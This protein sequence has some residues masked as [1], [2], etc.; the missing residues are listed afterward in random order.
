M[1]SKVKGGEF[2]RLICK[3]LSLWIS[4]GKRD[5]L[6][7][8]SAMSGG[9]ATV[10]KKKGK[11]VETQQGDISAIH[12]DGHKLTD[13]FIIECK[14]LHSLE[15]DRY[16]YGEGC[17]KLIW[18]KLLADGTSRL[19]MLVMKEYRKPIL[20]GLDY[21]VQ[22]HTLLAQYWSGMHVYYLDDLLNRPWKEVMKIGK[23]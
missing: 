2:E 23:K 11:Q 13:R 14:N 5:D 18:L 12:P 19:P 16:L 1:N 22:H 15:F 3:R 17:L 6:L 9:R 8:R 20:V 21:L 7:W 4:E 10:M